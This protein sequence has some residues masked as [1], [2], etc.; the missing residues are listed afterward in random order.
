MD[1]LWIVSSD[2]P[3]TIQHLGPSRQRLQATPHP[4]KRTDS[5]ILLDAPLF[6]LVGKFHY[7]AETPI[8][9]EFSL[10]FIP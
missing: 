10:V 5:D 6:F 3:S 2:V 4:S 7:I 1:G 8:S 9:L